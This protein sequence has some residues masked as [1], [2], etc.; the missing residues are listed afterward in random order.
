[1]DFQERLEKAIQ[2]GRRSQDAAAREQAER[3]LNEEELKR[4]HSQ[5]RLELSE[6]I[7]QCLRQ[8]PRHFPGFRY[9]TLV[10]DRGWG[11]A[12]SRDDL[13]LADGKRGNYFSR[14]EVV[15]RPYTSA[16]VLEL[17]AKGTI[18]N[19]ELFNRAQYQVLAD[20]DPATFSEQ[21]DRWVLEYVELYAAKG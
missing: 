6:H 16:H 3:A 17:A 8:L 20:A 18:R 14:L 1:M 2:R 5:Y 21:V 11:A 4:L 7:E 10:G 12:V 13:S 15:V 19:K 9:E